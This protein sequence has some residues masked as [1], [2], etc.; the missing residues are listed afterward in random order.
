MSKVYHGKEDKKKV[1]AI[2]AQF[3]CDED[4]VLVIF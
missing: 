3:D 2:F 1:E 4:D